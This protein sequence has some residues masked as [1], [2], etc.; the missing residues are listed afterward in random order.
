MEDGVKLFPKP[1]PPGERGLLSRAFA[2]GEIPV[3]DVEAPGSLFW[4]FEMPDGIPV[5]FGGIEVHAKEALIRGVL[6]LPPAQGRGIGRSMVAALETEAFVAGCGRIWVGPGVAPGFFAR[7]GY[8]PAHASDAP[9][10]I[11][12]ALGGGAAGVQGGAL[13][14]VKAL[15]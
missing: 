1:L 11:R 5:G 13:P 8:A 3:G 6:T 12:A 15:R 7:F 10:P 2:K 9:E 4:R 14:L